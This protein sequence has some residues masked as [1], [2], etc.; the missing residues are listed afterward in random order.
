MSDTDEFQD[1]RKPKKKKNNAQGH[2]G[3][4]MEISKLKEY[5]KVVKCKCLYQSYSYL[6]DV[7]IVLGDTV[8]DEIGLKDLK[9]E[10]MLWH[11]FPP[12]QVEDL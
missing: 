5:L 3:R 6:L 12:L 2:N 11:N 10:R 1:Y 7:I 4:N 8:Y 9:S